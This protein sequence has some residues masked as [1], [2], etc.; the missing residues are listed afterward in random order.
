MTNRHRA[1]GNVLRAVLLFAIYLGCFA[2]SDTWDKHYETDYSESESVHKNLIEI[3]SNTPNLSI[4]NKML[5]VTGYK[6]N[7]LNSA[8]A[9]TVWAPVDSAFNNTTIDW[10][11]TTSLHNMVKNHITRS[12]IPT[13]AAK[14]QRVLMLD[15]K[16]IYFSRFDN[17]YIFGGKKLVRSN[18]VA[19]N[20]I[21]HS[22]NGV[23]PFESNIWQ[24]LKYGVSTDSVKKFLYSHDVYKF[25]EDASTFLGTNSNGQRIYDSI[26]NYSNIILKKLGSL[27][28]EDSVYTMLVP[29]NTA[30]K[31]AYD[32]IKP[33][34]ACAST[35]GKRDSIQD[36]RTKLAIVNNLVFRGSL[37]SFSNNPTDSLVST[38]GNV[39]YSPARLFAGTAPETVSNG[40]VYKADELQFTPRESWQLPIIQDAELASSRKNV[41]NCKVYA[42]SSLSS[43]IKGISKNSYLYVVPNSSA[44]IPR[45]SFYLPNTLAGKYNIYCVFVPWSADRLGDSDN[46]PTKVKFRLIYLNANGTTTTQTNIIPADPIVYNGDN[47]TTMLVKENFTFPCADYYDSSANP[48]VELRVEANVASNETS[49]Y[50]RTMRIDCIVLKPVE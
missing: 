15:G 37:T 30:W 32:K 33:Y 28:V 45:V 3:I 35:I 11:D 13:S 12:S 50:T 8:Q 6:D 47:L 9:F 24:Y 4:F 10:N 1:K 16:F 21:L 22:I 5:E 20:G 40:L 49:Q 48:T 18:I 19:R 2:C 36:I 41:E 7:Y 29:S 34:F 27:S 26:F 44:A 25:D 14:G 38:T 42:K 46:K 43:S 31:A 23:V 39:F 17:Q